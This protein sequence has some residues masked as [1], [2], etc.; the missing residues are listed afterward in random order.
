MLHIQSLINW[1]CQPKFF[2]TPKTVSGTAVLTSKPIMTSTTSF[3]LS[4]P[5]GMP[6]SFDTFLS[7]VLK[8]APAPSKTTTKS[9]M[10]TSVPSSAIEFPSHRSLKIGTSSKE[11]VIISCHG[12]EISLTPDGVVTMTRSSPRPTQP[13]VCFLKWESSQKTKE[14]ASKPARKK[15]SEKLT[16]SSTTC[17]V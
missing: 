1:L 2:S 10:F 17:V 11:T 13:N 4:D 8:S 9:D 7:E 5:N 16:S 6:E 14:N 3:P 15:K 12:T